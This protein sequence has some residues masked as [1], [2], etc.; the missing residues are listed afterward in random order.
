MRLPCR[1]LSFLLLTFAAA[2]GQ[3]GSGMAP[4]NTTL[5]PTTHDP[6]FPI[7]A[8]TNHALGSDSPA[9][10]CN[11]CHGNNG[12][13]MQFDCVSCHQHSNQAALDSFH[14]GM[15]QYA[16]D[17]VKCYSCHAR[18]DAGG[19]F[20][21]GAT[22]D[23]ARN[24]SVGVQ[25]PSYVDTSLASFSIQTETL[26]MPMIHTSANVDAT[27][28]GSC[29]NCHVNAGSS[30]YYPG[31]F[32][33]SL[34]SLNTAQPTACGDCHAASV[35]SGFV[36]PT[37]TNPVRS[38]PSSEMKHDA[39]LWSNGK[40]TT[41]SAV[42]QEC[43]VCHTPPSVSMPARWAT[44]RSGTTPA[45]FHAS[46][47]AAGLP[48]STSCVD[49]HANSRPNGIWAI[50]S[51][52]L[53]FDHSIPMAMADC[54]SCHQGSSPAARWTSWSGGRYH[55]AGDATPATCLP[56]HA[57]ER[58]TTASNW[59]STTYTSAPFDYVTNAQ[60]ITHGAGQ[61]CVVCHGGP[62]TGAWGSTQ[63]WVGG[64]FVHGAG[65]MSSKT[66]IAC[67]STQRPDL[68]P[69]TT[70]AAMAALLNFDHSING[71]GDCS[72]CHQATVAANRYQYYF[73]P[74]TTQTL[75]GGD[76][77]GGEGYPGD[78][79]I[80]S[81]NQFVRV[82]EID[83]HRSGPNNLVTS[84]TSTATTLM[85]EILH[86]SS[87]I[88]PQ[89]SP[90]P[91]A[92]PDY[93]K[94]WHC[95]TSTGTTVTS[96]SDGVFHPALTNYSA[97]PGG[98]PTPLPQPTSQCFDC[99]VQMRPPGIVQ[100]A[101]SDLQPM[102]HNATLTS[103]V[104]IGGVSVTGVAGIECA[105]CHRSPGNTWADGVF[106]ANIGAAVPQDCTV[107]HYP[108]MVDA[109]R[110]D[111]TSGVN[112]TMKH[113]SSALTFQNCQVCHAGALSKSANTPIASTLWQGGAFHP[114][115]ASQPTACVTCHAVSLPPSNTPTQSSVTYSLALGVTSTNGGQGM[116]HG[117]SWVA[118][119][120]CVVCHAVDAKTSGS[121]WS[122]SD[123][124]HG[125]VSNVT[126][127]K[128]CHGVTNGGGSV[129][130][131]NNNLPV[132]LTNSTT[133]TSAASDNSTG[134]PAG[135]LDQIT[136]ADI[137]V[138]SHDC[139]F[140]HTQQGVSTV[141]GVQGKE[142]ARA[143]FHASFTSTNPLVMNGTTGRCSN[144]HM[145]VKPGASF[146]FDHSTFTNAAGSQ[147]CNSCH[148]WPGTGTP[149][150]ANWL[151]A[152]AAPAVVTL[153][154]WSSGTSITSSTVTFAHPRP[155]TYTSCAQCHVGT[156]FSTIVD[157]NHDGLT[158]NVTIDGVTPAAQ[159][160]LG[161]TQY[162][163]STN[164]TF[165]VHC[166]NSKS[167]WINNSRSSTI[168]AN[169]TSGSTTVTTA[170]TSALTLGMRVTGTGIPSSTSTNT[171]FTASTTAGSTT[172]TTASPIS[173]SAGT[174]ITGPGIPANDTVAASVSNATS[175]TLK[176]AATATASG[177]TLTATRT[178]A[179]TVTINTIP[180][181]TTF[182]VSTA[183]NAT[184]TG[185]TLSVTHASIQQASIGSHGGSTNGQDCTSCHYVR[186][187]ERLT[188]PTAGV[189]A[190]G[191]ISGN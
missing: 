119:K 151:G 126:S 184:V 13:F 10:S 179:L 60:A 133:V 1:T 65:T 36:G 33:A 125:H 175:F 34:V 87:A 61:D 80:G 16:Y 117:S 127:C 12:S 165:C 50:G 163:A 49:C 111:L 161:T 150:A 52:N 170:S 156:N 154:G 5:D 2:C 44:N 76:W 169:T 29:I 70:P 28:L 167:P 90:G 71:M 19:A 25:I 180:S 183:A 143:N 53:Q 92:T 159:P 6:F 173:L 41:T 54:A 120:D 131:T 129:A 124:F 101:A 85:N 191:S 68:L 45:L 88:P 132:G 86:V 96:F 26:P 84:M 107:C 187:P 91:T 134:I 81:A 69:G 158:S 55:F 160:N 82:T 152:A 162:N 89:V 166:H 35:P 31:D 146:A 142:W 115:L 164:P 155:S 8:G 62:G 182:T 37:A 75:P 3:G 21:P 43:G 27:A 110:S 22:S 123:S 95:H 147:D 104:T 42:P 66:C 79:L 105:V 112:Y 17:S 4:W 138:T 136:H 139:N 48:Q 38:P 181:A 97:T 57:G 186:G 23:P 188:P 7:A 63:N 73:K 177:V 14:R 145:N 144:C 40:P 113:A 93:A 135:T 72:G 189:F 190:T 130:G 56:C 109:A 149:T 153:T 30:A 141:A 103:A 59:T 121:A 172:V 78:T 99:H 122:K 128:E 176:T 116:N 32:H 51:T 77:Q 94:C 39:V 18:G 168:T 118:G 148:A 102:D 9:I 140:C 83:L 108:L 67:H 185:T 106:H 114:S 174:L 58:P 171:N 64:R 20:P 47:T 178:T 24:V 11:S 100:K 74:G 46:L 15:T 137:N 157:F 98:T